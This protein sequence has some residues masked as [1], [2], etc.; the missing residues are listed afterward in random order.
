MWFRN[1]IVYSVP[2]GWDLSAEALA[3]LLAPQAFA[4]GSSIEEL[5]IG[6]VP[7]KEGDSALVYAVDRQ[8]LLTLRHEKKLLPAKVIAQV[9]KQ[10][11][12]KLEEE[13]G[14][15]PGRKRLKELKELVR[16]ELLPRAFSLSSDT[17][18]WIDPVHGWLAVDT[19][20]ANKAGEI[21]SL[22]VKAIDG[23]P[24]RSL[25]VT[26]SVPGEMTAWLS[27]GEAPAGFTVDQDAELKARD[28]KATVRFANQ[29]LE[30]DDVA[31]HTKA[32]KHCTKLALT[33]ESRIS[34]LLTDKLEIKR[35]RALDILKEAGGNTEGDADE[36]F[37]ADAMLMTGELA[38]LL[39][40]VVEAL[41]GRQV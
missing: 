40:E 24:G 6:W 41:G 33:W 19:G 20:S 7:P 13:E 12:E 2:V 38:K 31:R 28:G 5:S 16:D 18:V 8:M 14:F 32:G 17:R 11:A 4:P 15:K 25:K 35:I 9:V 22:L 21:Y 36:R 39:A 27:T 37:T 1:L 23:F 10:R 26:A 3:D 29:S 34:F 30:L